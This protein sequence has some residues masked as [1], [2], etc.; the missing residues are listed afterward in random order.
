MDIWLG[1]EFCEIYPIYALPSRN[2]A[3]SG[4]MSRR[5]SPLIIR[6]QVITDKDTGG[7]VIVQ[8]QT[9]RSCR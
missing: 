1:W 8:C 7:N 3:L 5:R 4:V 2:L 9:E 6:L